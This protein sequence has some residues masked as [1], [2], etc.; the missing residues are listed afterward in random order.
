MIW[1][2]VCAGGDNYYLFVFNGSHMM[3]YLSIVFLFLSPISLIN[4]ICFS[5]CRVL[6]P[7][8]LTMNVKITLKSLGD[9]FQGEIFD[10]ALTRKQYGNRN[11]VLRL[12]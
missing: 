1:D 2:W 6:D 12:K 4:L 7:K 3:I 9:V 11:H 10:I 5:T 8:L